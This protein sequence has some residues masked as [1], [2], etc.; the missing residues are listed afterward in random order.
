M[1][2]R[3]VVL[4]P[5]LPWPLDDGGRI[6]LWQTVWAAAQEFE[7]TLVTLIPPEEKSAPLPATIEKL[8]IEVIRIPHR[9]PPLPLAAWRGLAGPWPYTLARYQNRELAN[10][11]RKVAT[12]RKPRF[13]LVNNL[14]MAPYVESMAGVPMVLREQNLEYRWMAR[15]AEGLPPGPKRWYAQLQAGRLRAAEVELCQ[16]S[17]LVF[18]IQDDET[19]VVRRLVPTARVE[20][21]PVGI[22]TDAY[23]SPRPADPPVVLLAGAFGWPPNA[24]GAVRFLQRGWAAVARQV[25]RARLRI[26]GKDPPPFLL[27][28]AQRAGA[29]VTGYV[30][31]MPAE[32]AQASVLLVPLWVGAG[33]RVKII[34]A[35]TAGL[36]VAS[37][38]IG[39]E[40]LGIDPEEDYLLSDTAEGL[41]EKVISLLKSPERRRAL[42]LR[43]REIA[44]SRWS[45]GAVAAIQNR[46][47]REISS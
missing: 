47:C 2:N 6:A 13:F 30:D 8:G 42:S 9:P 27:N 29:E 33:A 15:Y 12:K 35:L 28:E 3:A 11:L 14:H 25:P 45:L 21:L 7:T 34:E 10:E 41:A 32:F 22:D 38:S 44:R 37:T 24:D 18:A 5:R 40:G 1:R 31:S 43:G 19:A 23:M 4:T 46:L 39:V 20:T 17:A 26:A 36:P 16:Q